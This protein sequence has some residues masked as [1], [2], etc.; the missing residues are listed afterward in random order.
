MTKIIEMFPRNNQSLISIQ[1]SLNRGEQVTIRIPNTKGISSKDIEKLLELN[2]SSL[3]NVNIYGAHRNVELHF[4]RNI[5]KEATTY[6]LKELKEIMYEI[7]DIENGINPNFDDLQKLVYFLGEIGNRVVYDAKVSKSIALEQSFTMDLKDTSTLRSLV[8]GS[9][10]CAGYSLILKEMCDRN[11]IECE[12]MIGDIKKK[13]LDKENL[14]ARHAWNAV[15]INGNIIPIDS[16]WMICK[17]N[18]GNTYSYLSLLSTSEFVAKHF[19]LIHEKYKDKSMYK[20]I[21]PELL[22]KLF[23][24]I[25]K[26]VKYNRT[27]FRSKRKDG[28]EFQITQIEQIIVEHTPV[29]KY[30]YRDIKE[31]GTFG[32]PII[33]Y[34]KTNVANIVQQISDVKDKKTLQRNL[35]INDTIDNVL[36]SKVNIERA[37]KDRTCYLG[38]VINNTEVAIDN[39]LGKKAH[40]LQARFKRNDGSYF[41]IQ[42]SKLV[43]KDGVR[44]YDLYEYIKSKGK[45]RCTKTTIF[46][47]MDL[48]HTNEDI[49]NTILDRSNIERKKKETNG[50][51]GYIENAERHSNQRLA[52]YFKEDIYRELAAKSNDITDEFIKF[53]EMK[54]LV[55]T[56]KMEYVNNEKKFFNRVTGREITDKEICLKVDFA[57]LWLNSATVYKRD[58]ESIKGFD[59]AFSEASEE[60]FNKISSFIKNNMTKYQEFDLHALYDYIEKNSNHS[61]S[62]EIISRLFSTKE[63][64]ELIRKAIIQ[65][66]NT[67]MDDTVE[68]KHLQDGPI[69]SPDVAGMFYLKFDNERR[70]ELKKIDMAVINSDGEVE[71]Q[72]PQK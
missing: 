5:Y 38:E 49:A 50:Y 68:M 22:K 28:T 44:C 32:K 46:T 16:T 59:S 17:K 48:F 61:Y 15:V 37:T 65:N 40:Q 58:N 36:F 53:D 24:F 62:F 30:M 14:R 72:K 25:N 67:T 33:L 63:N 12:F 20:T 45:I 52:K 34:S 57:Y 71:I 9:G 35:I 70:E 19:P 51:I 27:T 8:S 13:G 21:N 10:V 18:K 31:D 69:M 3:L 56:Y 41:I 42:E 11:N 43:N 4:G 39:E 2:N 64:C 54:R 29:Y 1:E 26:D 60:L 7:E 66:G 55:K 6:S 47:E 23:S